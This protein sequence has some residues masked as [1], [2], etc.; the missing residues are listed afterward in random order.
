MPKMNR[1]DLFPVPVRIDFFRFSIS[2]QGSVTQTFLL[3]ES[4]KVNDNF[5]QNEA[6]AIFFFQRKTNNIFFKEKLTIFFSKKKYPSHQKLQIF[7]S[8]LT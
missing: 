7:Y 4:Q 3:K 8:A 1:I 2:G 5:G 6:L